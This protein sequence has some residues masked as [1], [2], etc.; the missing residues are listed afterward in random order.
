MW[1]TRIILK[2]KLRRILKKINAISIYHPETFLLLQLVRLLKPKLFSRYKHDLGLSFSLTTRYTNIELLNL[3][4]KEANRYLKKKAS[5]P[6]SFDS[7]TERVVSIDRFLISN[8]N[9]YVNIEESLTEFQTQALFLLTELNKIEDSEYG[10]EA[11]N[12]RILTKFLINIKEV[13]TK[14]I[15]ISVV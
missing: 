14:L 13:T 12:F 3:K 8:D 7:L 10:I 2:W 1:I 4:I 6:I 9:T 11:Y 5:I 15:E